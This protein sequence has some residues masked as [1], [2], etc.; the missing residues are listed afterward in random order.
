MRQLARSYEQGAPHTISWLLVT[1]C[2]TVCINTCFRNGVKIMFFRHTCSW[3][4]LYDTAMLL[5]EWTTTEFWIWIQYNSFVTMRFRVSV[6]LHFQMLRKSWDLPPYTKFDDRVPTLACTRSGEYSLYSLTRKPS[7]R[8][9]KQRQTHES[10]RNYWIEYL[11]LKHTTSQ[12]LKI[13]LLMEPFPWGRKENIRNPTALWSR[14]MNSS[15]N[16]VISSGF[17]LLLRRTLWYSGQ[18]S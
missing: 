4:G 6:Y 12:N 14:C 9:N 5:L 2:A 13:L 8:G 18:V 3:D 17:G 15:R 10:N 16:A 7:C 1:A 11:H